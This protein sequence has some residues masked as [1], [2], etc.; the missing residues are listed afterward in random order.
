VLSS[1]KFRRFPAPTDHNIWAVLDGEIA[2]SISPVETVGFP[3]EKRSWF[4]VDTDGAVGP[5]P[6]GDPTPSWPPLRVTEAAAETNG[7]SNAV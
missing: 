5:L 4:I 6:E 2:A 1:E 7:P 3:V